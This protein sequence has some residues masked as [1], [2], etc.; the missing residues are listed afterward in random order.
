MRD[1]LTPRY[2]WLFILMGRLE[3]GVKFLVDLRADVL[4]GVDAEDSNVSTIL[5]FSILFLFSN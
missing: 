2:Q 5:L 4:V 1:A 3:H